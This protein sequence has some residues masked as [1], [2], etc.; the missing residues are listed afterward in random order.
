M[1]PIKNRVN[2]FY[3]LAIIVG[4]LFSVT[5]CAYVVMTVRQLNSPGSLE[6]NELMQWVDQHGLTAFV[7]ELAVLAV[8]TLAAIAS[9]RMWSGS[10][11]GQPREERD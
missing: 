4:V 3:V 5:A 6:T 2:P 10:N 7:T 1:K 11:A 9:D 8:A